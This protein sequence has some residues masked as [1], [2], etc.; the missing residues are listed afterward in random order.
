MYFFLIWCIW[1]FY[2]CALLNPY[3]IVPKC[4]PTIVFIVFVE[5]LTECNCHRVKKTHFGTVPFSSCCRWALRLVY[6]L[7][8]CNQNGKPEVNFLNTSAQH[9]GLRK[10]SDLEE[11]KLAEYLVSCYCLG[12]W[13]R[14]IFACNI[15]HN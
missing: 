5:L 8:V 7:V 12:N 15:Y 2:E 9:G 6:L 3:T 13:L 4:V 1:T 10:V 11:Q 14:N